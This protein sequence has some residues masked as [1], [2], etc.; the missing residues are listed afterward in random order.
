MFLALIKHV[1]LGYWETDVRYQR[2][3]MSVVIT[4]IGSYE[5]A[6]PIRSVI[7]AHN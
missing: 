3:L 4:Y 1:Y 7:H 5:I 6:H 2:L